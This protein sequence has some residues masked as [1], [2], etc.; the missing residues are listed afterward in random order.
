MAADKPKP[1]TV[2]VDGI[3]VTVSID[4]SDDY[5]FAVCSMTIND[6][7]ATADERA[8]ALVRM[9]R[10]ALG[11]AYQRVMDEL[12]SKNGGRLPI[13]AVSAFVNKV[14]SAEGGDA[15]N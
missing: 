11:D 14:I 7:N 8:G 2:E 3:E 13:S 4:P 5:E 10:L 12:R 1:K 9:H 6:Q 15:K